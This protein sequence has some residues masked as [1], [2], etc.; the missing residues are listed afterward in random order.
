MGVDKTARVTPRRGIGMPGGGGGGG[1]GNL[2]PGQPSYCDCAQ[3]TKG[4]H[5]MEHVRFLQNAG[6]GLL[7]L[8]SCQPFGAQRAWDAC[9]C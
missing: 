5:L 1:L 6:A 9:M 4:A 8:D 2:L 3:S 7:W